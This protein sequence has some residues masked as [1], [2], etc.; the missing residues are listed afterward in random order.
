MTDTIQVPANWL[1]KLLDRFT[2]K[3][4]EPQP[5]PTPAPQQQAP[6]PQPHVEQFTAL[7]QERDNLTAELGAAKAEVER[8]KA[9]RQREQT[10]TQ[11]VAE[12]RDQQR[13]GG[14]FTELAA[15][16]EAADVLGGMTDEQRA[17]VVKHFS[18]LANQVKASALFSERGSSGEGAPANPVQALHAAV[19]AVMTERKVD[20]AAALDLIAAEQPG[21]IEAAYPRGRG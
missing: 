3:G 7:Q 17:W 21:L 6:E 5:D 8:L 11:L 12:L 19:S 10:R 2:A 13:F 16:N 18:A 4:P 15:A 9:E 20:Y 1:E 14:M